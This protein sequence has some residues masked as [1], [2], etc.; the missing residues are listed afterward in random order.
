MPL[1]DKLPLKDFCGEISF[2][3]TKRARKGVVYHKNRQDYELLFHESPDCIGS[4]QV[5][6]GD[7]ILI[8]AQD[9]LLKPN[10]SLKLYSE[11]DGQD[12]TERKEF[13]NK[14]FI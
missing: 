5:K 6:A 13:L 10:I 4:F 14:F 8:Q 3:D 7:L 1:I 11:A 9:Y 12:Y 2:T